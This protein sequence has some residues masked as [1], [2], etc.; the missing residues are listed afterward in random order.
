MTS[1][2]NHA[3]PSEFVCVDVHAE[4]E[5]GSQKKKNTEGAFLYIVEGDCDHALPCKPYIDHY[6]LT[7]V[8]CTK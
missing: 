1:H 3:H 8:V 2:Y 6:E 4:A 7:C 5:Q